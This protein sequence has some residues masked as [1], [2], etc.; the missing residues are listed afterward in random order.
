MFNYSIMSSTNTIDENGAH[1]PNRRDDRREELFAAALGQFARFGYKRARIEDIAAELGLTKGAVY[2][3]AAGK[4]ELYREA[5]AWALGEWCSAIE[6][7]A[8]LASGAAERLGV[9]ARASF[10]YLDGYPDLR[11]IVAQDRSLYSLDPAADRFASVNERARGLLRDTLE[12]GV[13]SGDFRRDID[14]DAAS[15]FLYQVYIAFL[16]KAFA[17]GE[18]A[19]AAAQY[20]AGVD[21]ALKGLLAR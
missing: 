5:I 21:I 3:Y 2:F 17:L 14:A 10:E 18:G 6:R 16:I 12:E 7:D 15:R 11:A 13:R 1:T 19:E 4:D 8:A 20:A 9:L